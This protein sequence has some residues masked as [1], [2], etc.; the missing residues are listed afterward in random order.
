M[1]RCPIGDLVLWFRGDEGS[2]IQV[3]TAKFIGL[4]FVNRTG[5]LADFKGIRTNEINL[6]FENYF[7]RRLLSL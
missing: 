1:R 6:V 4:H 3:R 7:A 2:K 5:F